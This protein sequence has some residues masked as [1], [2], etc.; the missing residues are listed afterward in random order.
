M[1][2]SGLALTLSNLRVTFPQR[3]APAV[4]AASTDHLHLPAGHHLGIAGPSGSGKT[5]LLHVIAG[6]LNPTQGAVRWGAHDLATMPEGARDAWRRR[7]LGLI[8]QDFHLIPELD[9]RANV[10]LP[11]G[12]G[13]GRHATAS[14]ADAILDTM[15]IPD[16]RRRAANLS[17]GEQQ[18][19]AI[20]RALLAAPAIILA[21]EPTASLDAATGRLVID[22]LLASAT[23]LGATLIIVS[24]D[25]ALLARL[26]ATR[27]MHAGHM[28]PATP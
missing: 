23:S 19:V 18:R 9:A 22:L 1:P 16:P 20:A 26:P 25:P 11:T 8:F 17:R 13:P 12:F 10:L 14:Q 28:N 15:G 6:L 3:A 27:R 5:T 21:D 7:H 2:E 4:T 24:H